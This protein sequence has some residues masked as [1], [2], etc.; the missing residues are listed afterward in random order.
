MRV[1][2][3]SCGL[4]HEVIRVLDDG[5]GEVQRLVYE[6]APLENCTRSWLSEKEMAEAAKRFGLETLI[7]D[8]DED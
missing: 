2:C 8:S 6:V 3:P 4:H 7:T 1:L 5:F